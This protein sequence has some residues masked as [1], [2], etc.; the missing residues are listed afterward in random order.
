MA[1]PT[2]YTEHTLAE[3][4]HDELGKVAT[5]LGYAVGVA[6]AG[7]Y[8]EA[9]IEAQITFGGAIAT[10]DASTVPE[11]RALARIE[12]WRKAV[13]DLVTYYKFSAEGSAF[14]REAVL[15]NA[16]KNLERAY[17]AAAAFITLP[18]DYASKVAALAAAAQAAVDAA[19]ATAL[20]GS[21]MD[22]LEAKI[23]GDDALLDVKIAADTAA[24]LAKAGV[25]TAA[26]SAKAT[27]DDALLDVKIAGD[28]ALQGAKIAADL[29]LL[30]AK[31]AAD[32][33]AALAKT[34]AAIA[35]AALIAAAKV[36]DATTDPNYVIGIDRVRPVN[37]PYRWIPEDERTL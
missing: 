1:V 8:A 15:L 23:A 6:D 13:N 20:F 37:D 33:A 26:A 7:S 19:A 29:A 28:S 31:I 34:N 10:V 18:F 4:M 17:A 11:I 14:E 9:V 35:A 27:A 32:S 16:T 5:L 25:D 2:S 30:N 12:A 22:L 36:Y 21:E 3:Y 24:A